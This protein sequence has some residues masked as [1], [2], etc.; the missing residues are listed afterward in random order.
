MIYITGKEET[1]D[2]LMKIDGYQGSSTEYK[3][4]LLFLNPHL[5]NTSISAYTEPYTPICLLNDS[6]EEMQGIA[7]KLNGSITEIREYLW[8]L[9][10]ENRL[11]ENAI[12]A[13]FEIMDE[14]QV[15]RGK[16]EKK[17][18]SSILI[19][20]LLLF[21]LLAYVIAKG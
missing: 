5:N 2:Q 11:D 15:Y 17:S 20:L 10:S 3:K 19:F 1:I 4:K 13:A 6:S 16:K 18:I 14:Y 21:A 8:E 12:E 7:E 9:Q